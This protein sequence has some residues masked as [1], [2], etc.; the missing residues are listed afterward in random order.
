MTITIFENSKDDN[1]DDEKLCT[2][3]NIDAIPRKGDELI[4]NEKS[5][6]VDNFLWI[7]DGEPL[8]T[9]WVNLN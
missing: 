8:V 3:Y 6:T 2:L 5:Y 4:I 1:L 7:L 9:I